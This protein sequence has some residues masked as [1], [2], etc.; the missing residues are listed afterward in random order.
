MEP[1]RSVVDS[2]S[3]WPEP[4]ESV[5]QALPPTGPAP[6]NAHRQDLSQADRFFMG[7]VVAIPRELRYGAVTWLGGAFQVSRQTV[8]D[9]ASRLDV[10]SGNGQ[11][12]APV[13]VVAA[14]DAA[15][16]S[17]TTLVRMPRLIL[18]MLVPGG[19]SYRPMRVCLREAFGQ[20]RSIGFISQLIHRDG[21]RAG[22]ILAA[23]R[24]PENPPELW[25]SRDE[26]YF[27]GRPMQ[28]TVDPH[29]LV[30][31]SG[32]V[33]ETAD[34]KGW[35]I[36][37]SVLLE[38]YG[39]CHVRIAEDGATFYPAS[40]TEAERLLAEAGIPCLF[41]VQ[42]DT[43]HVS[44]AAQRLQRT[45]DRLAFKTLA[46]VE[47][48]QRPC[49]Q[50]SFTLITDVA[51]WRKA[52]KA[53]SRAIARAD[54][55]RF[56]V[57]SLHD[58]FE[59]VDI[60]CGAVR[61]FAIN[62]WLLDETIQG[63]HALGDPA[64]TKL[65][66]TLA[67]QQ[68]QLLTYM[69]WL[70]RELQ[71][72]RRDNLAHFGDAELATILERA[73]AR[74]WRLRRAVTNGRH[75]LRPAAERAAAHLDRLIGQD[76]VARQLADRLIALLDAV[77]RTTWASENVNSI[78]KPIVWAHR[79]FADRQSAQYWLNLFILWHNMRRFERGKETS[80]NC[81]RCRWWR[82][83]FPRHSSVPSVVGA[84]VRTGR[85]PPGDGRGPSLLP[86]RAR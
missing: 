86:R 22:E 60:S 64:A 62:Q 42:K 67:D 51:A 16:E 84:G 52:K 12:P 38:G 43:R 15:T 56:W 70:D 23:V 13:L 83:T 80:S 77:V 61:D 79:H 7:A 28:L 26:T 46:Q 45:L 25:V 82:R 69:L 63:L 36:Q 18:S 27:S 73:A 59:I 37:L 76:D 32:Q 78:L 10:G 2:S 50:K 71:A 4:M 66:R 3:A 53:A 9:I 33:H 40:L 19:M 20:T 39:P 81:K 14:P 57:D 29:N 8:Y 34:G 68:P 85:L 48:Y 6:G 5:Y 11:S 31:T 35:A 75:D 47:R 41:T 30:I 1:Y 21:E 72:W 24:W 55:L 65:A 54:A 74:T 58:A 44:V 17:Q 49:F